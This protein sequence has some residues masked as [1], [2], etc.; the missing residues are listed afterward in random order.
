MIKRAFIACA[1]LVALSVAGRAQAQDDPSKPIRLVVP[2]PPGGSNDVLARV[3]AEKLSISMGQPVLVENK[4]GASGNIGADFVAKAPPDGHTLLIAANNILTMNAALYQRMPFASTDFKAISMLATIPIVLVAGPST[5]AASVGELIAA[6]RNDPGKL[7]Y[8][9]S[10]MGSPQ[11]LSAELFKS[12]T[13][14]FIVHIPYKGQ[15]PA[16]MDLIGG[17]VNVVFGAAN[18]LLPHIKSG[19]LRA[20]GVTGRSRA[21]VLPDVPTI[22][23]AGVPGYESDTWVGLVAPAKTPVAIVERLN[24]EIRKAFALPDVIDNLAQQAI[25]AQTSTSAEF[26]KLITEDVKRWAAVIKNAGIKAE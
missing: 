21:R 20:L 9:S 16:I 26:E 7:T 13:K 5:H 19:R 23:E 18:S 6:A 12:M 1:V 17:Q 3:L 2:W 8:A 4:P 25:Y 15:A 11:H 22:A 10:G 24:R 14:T